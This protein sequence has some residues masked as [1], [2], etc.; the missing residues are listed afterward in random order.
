MNLN[1][2]KRWK[3]PYLSDN[4]EIQGKYYL[5]VKTKVGYFITSGV[6]VILA[7]GKVMG[8]DILLNKNSDTQS[9]IYNNEY[10][11]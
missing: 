3:G 10:L 2:P 11:L 7:N 5:V 1:Y 4:P 6:G 9:M 8:K